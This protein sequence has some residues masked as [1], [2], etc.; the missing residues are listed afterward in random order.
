MRILQLLTV[1]LWGT[2]S[3]TYARELSYS[4]ASLGHTPAVLTPEH[5]KLENVVVYNIKL[6]FHATFTGHPEWRD[7][8]LFTELTDEEIST[9]YDAWL[10]VALE[11]VKDFKPDVIHV[12]HALILS[13]V[14]AQI[15][16]TTGKKYIVSVHGTCITTAE[17]DPRY[18]PRTRTALEES[19]CIVPVSDY[20]KNQMLK[21]FGDDLAKKCRVITGG[22]SLDSFKKGVDTSLVDKN[23][24]LHG[25]RMVLFSGRL[26]AIK[27]ADYLIRAAPFINAEICI[28]G[29][30]PELNKLKALTKEVRVNNVEFLGYF[31]KDQAN[32]LSQ[33]YARAD[34]LVMP[35]VAD[36]ALGLASLEAMSASTPVV[37]SN[38]GGIP[39]VVRH[40]VNGFLIEPRSPE[41]IADSVNKILAD[42]NLRL[43][44]GKNAREMVERN[45]SWRKI[46]QDFLPLY[47]MS[48]Q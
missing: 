34:V 4:L 14:A 38:V 17:K 47:D 3:G 36:E 15:K 29:E 18:I 10:N 39:M 37:A 19:E 26:S 8:K 48:R 22:V 1:P 44:M 32:L 46:A 40:G 12:H 16:A 5:R 21:V 9:Y 35:S 28:V 20:T 31:E 23:Y 2:G 33:I 41:K 13:W 27:G 30:G 7:A 43:Q 6:P 24:E 25:R 11:I 45:F 42:D